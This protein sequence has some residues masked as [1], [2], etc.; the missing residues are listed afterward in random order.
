MKK[1]LIFFIALSCNVALRAQQKLTPVAAQS[2][3]NFTIRNFGFNTRGDL[4][5][6]KGK[7]YFDKNHLAQSSFDITVDVATI[8][9]GNS[10][11]DRHL[12]A[13]DYFDVAKY[14]AI[15]IAGKPVLDKEGKFLFQ[16]TLTIKNITKAIAFPFTLSAQNQGYL[17][18]ASFKINRLTYQVGNESAVLSDDLKVMLKVMAK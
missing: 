13:A 16:G 18:E 14:P 7:L 6:L 17:F 5:G 12:L 11:R 8:N 4:S 15:R 2:S 9:T 3:I 1:C 10:Q